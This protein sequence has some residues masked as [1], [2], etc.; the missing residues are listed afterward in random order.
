MIVKLQL[1]MPQLLVVTLSISASYYIPTNYTV[2]V[3]TSSLRAMV[4]DVSDAV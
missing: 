4:T 1:W 2:I 3:K